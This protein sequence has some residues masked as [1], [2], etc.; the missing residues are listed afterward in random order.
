MTCCSKCQAKILQ[1]HC[2]YSEHFFK[3][4]LILIHINQVFPLNFECMSS[5][6]ETCFG[7]WSHVQCQM[8]SLVVNFE[9]C[10][11]IRGLRRC[12]LKRI[13]STVFIVVNQF[14]SLEFGNCIRS[15]CTLPESDLTLTLFFICYRC[16]SAL[17]S[18]EQL[19]RKSLH[20]SNA[21]HTK[22]Y[23]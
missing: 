20:F 11:S 9:S 7:C 14:Y 10:V 12:R 5:S 13:T 17:K 23:Q 19:Q 15:T 18:D 4:I 16:K 6:S 2:D 3:V 21:I 22:L 1:Y 8:K